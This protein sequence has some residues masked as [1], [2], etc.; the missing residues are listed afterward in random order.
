MADHALHELHVRRYIV[1]LLRAEG[2]GQEQANDLYTSYC[3]SVED[4]VA[5]LQ[6]QR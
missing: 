5:M 2:A 1:G 3:H 6:P 4:N